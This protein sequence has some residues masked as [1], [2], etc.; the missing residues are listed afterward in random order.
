LAILMRKA[1]GFSELVQA[2]GTSPEGAALM[3]LSEQMPKLVE[4][5]VKA[6]SNL[7][8]DKVTV[9]DTGRDASG[10]NSTANFVSGLM[11]ALPPI[12]DIARNAGVQL[13]EFLGKLSQDPERLLSLSHELTRKAEEVQGRRATARE[14]LKQH[15]AHLVSFDLNADSNID[16]AEM[17][18]AVKTAMD[19]ATLIG[20]GAGGWFYAVGEK[21][22]GPHTW[23]EILAVAKKR[24]GVFIG[25][26]D[27][28]FWLPLPVLRLALGDAA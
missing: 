3:L 18:T 23:E 2:C 26:E 15:R 22:V 19:W 1:E 13:P 6:I 24:P 11:G 7:K 17:E 5:Q 14:W 28:P 27:A 21:S 4:G 12:H 9:W 10:K 20:R 25:R 8:I 16:D